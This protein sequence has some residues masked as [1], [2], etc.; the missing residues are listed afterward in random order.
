MPR[1]ATARPK[2]VSFLGGRAYGWA[3]LDPGLNVEEPAFV[4]QALEL[5]AIPGCADHI[6]A[7]LTVIGLL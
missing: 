3:M 4:D 7:L 5:Y 1:K 2:A 6:A